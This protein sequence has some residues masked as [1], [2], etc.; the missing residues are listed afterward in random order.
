MS[1]ERADRTKY[2]LRNLPPQDYRRLLSGP[3]ISREAIHAAATRETSP[4]KQKTGEEMDQLLK[5]LTEQLRQQQEE[6]RQ[7]KEEQR[8]REEQEEKCK[9]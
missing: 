5:L 8:Q 1:E 7:E 6:H 4:G 9:Q 3:L 2:Q